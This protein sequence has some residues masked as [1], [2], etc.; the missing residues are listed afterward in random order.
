MILC[1]MIWAMFGVINLAVYY[2]T[3]EPKIFWNDKRLAAVEVDRKQQV[4]VQD[5]CKALAL[6]YTLDGNE[7]IV[8]GEAAQVIQLGDLSPALSYSTNTAVS[9][10]PLENL[11][12]IVYRRRSPYRC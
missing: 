12:A 5:F 8:G 10:V 2:N 9:R 6:D 11:W 4:G 7:L 3:P 1:C